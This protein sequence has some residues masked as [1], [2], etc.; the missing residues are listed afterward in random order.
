MNTEIS[1]NG[2]MALE[3][4]S[5]RGMITITIPENRTTVS[6][7]LVLTALSVLNGNRISPWHCRLILGL[8]LTWL[9]ERVFLS[10]ASLASVIHSTGKLFMVKNEKG[11]LRLE[12]AFFMKNAINRQS[13]S[14]SGSIL[15]TYRSHFSITAFIS[16]GSS[17]S[18]YIFLPLPGCIKPSDC[19]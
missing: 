14:S 19:A 12:T 11:C 13:V 1:F 18:K 4:I 16:S 3:R 5:V 15:I 10:K 7:L 6:F 9:E 17:V 2:I 8:V